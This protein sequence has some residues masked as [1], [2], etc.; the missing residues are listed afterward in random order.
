MQHTMQIGTAHSGASL[1]PGYWYLQYSSKQAL[2]NVSVLHPPRT[3]RGRVRT[4]YEQLWI[5][6]LL[7]GRGYYSTFG[8]PPRYASRLDISL[9]S[10][11]SVT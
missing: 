4:R 7:I 5:E 10:A 3:R 8:A 1:G 2:L 11:F 6:P 9:E